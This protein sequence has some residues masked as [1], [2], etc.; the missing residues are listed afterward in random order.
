MRLPENFIMG[1]AT[2]A[3]QCEGE[4]KTHGRLSGKTGL[5]QP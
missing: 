5:V 3:Y 2:A 1:G 4:S